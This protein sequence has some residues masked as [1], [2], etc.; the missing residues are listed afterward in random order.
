MR[1]HLVL[2]LL[3]NYLTVVLAGSWTALREP[4]S[5][6]AHPYVH[7]VEC[8]RQNYLRLDC[9]DDCNGQQLLATRLPKGMTD[10]TDDGLS[11]KMLD[12]HLPAAAL[13]LLP[14]PASYAHCETVLFRL[15]S[16][17]VIT[18]LLPVVGPP[19]ETSLAFA[20]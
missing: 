15:P 13:P 6:E 3:L 7:S 11:L 17:S 12:C 19:P 18:V 1:S 2:L 20:C 14:P 4:A 16:A 5:T 9:F 10:Q 8:Q